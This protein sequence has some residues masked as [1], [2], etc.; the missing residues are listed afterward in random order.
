MY[1]CVVYERL[2]RPGRRTSA[3]SARP[4]HLPKIRK[5]LVNTT[6]EDSRVVKSIR[7][8]VLRFW[9]LLFRKDSA[10]LE[11]TVVAKLQ[12]SAE[13]LFRKMADYAHPDAGIRT[14]AFLSL[15][16]IQVLFGVLPVLA[17]K[18][19]IFSSDQDPPKKIKKIIEN[20]LHVIREASFNTQHTVGSRLVEKGRLIIPLFCWLRYPSLSTPTIGVMEELLSAVLES[21]DIMQVPNYVEIVEKLTVLGLA[22]FTHILSLVLYEHERVDPT[23]M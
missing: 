9:E 10:L 19:K 7:K 18:Y 5:T 11:D 1:R 4:K 17:E 8:S 12:E 2:G 23:S 22:S 6:G 3:P 21:P 14:E 20:I 16:G 15:G 13:F